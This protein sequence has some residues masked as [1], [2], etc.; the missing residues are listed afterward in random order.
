MSSEGDGRGRAVL[1]GSATELARAAKAAAGRHV[2]VVAERTV[3]EWYRLVEDD[4]RRDHH[5]VKI[6]GE[7]REATTDDRVT[8]RELRPQLHVSAAREPVAESWTAAVERALDGAEEAFVAFEDPTFLLTADAPESR[9]A[10]LT[11]FTDRAEVALA[12]PDDDVI[13]VG[14]LA[15]FVRAA[16]DETHR[17]LADDGIEYL[18]TVD[19][20]NFGYLRSNWREARRGLE[21]VEMTYPQSKQ[22]HDAIPD[23]ETTPRTLGAALQA[24]VELGGLDVWGDTVAANRY[25]M[26]AYDP[27]RVAAVGAAIDRLDE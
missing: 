3:R 25:D 10:E 8:T 27:E 20:T 24:L 11:A 14:R 2:G 21:A 7:F 22:V 15:R 18:R 6:G 23:P 4:G 13:N 26:T 9:L 16:D 12:V 5:V 1:H 17:R 19:P